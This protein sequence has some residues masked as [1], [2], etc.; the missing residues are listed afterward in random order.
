MVKKY[1]LNYKKGRLNPLVL[2]TKNTPEIGEKSDK[3]QESLQ[4][5]GY[6]Q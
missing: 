3:K 1:R 2:K 5:N 6:T 4:R